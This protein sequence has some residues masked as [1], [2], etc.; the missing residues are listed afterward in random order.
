MRPASLGPVGD[1]PGTIIDLTGGQRF[2][3]QVRFGD[4]LL[5]H[6]P[7]GLLVVLPEVAELAAGGR[8]V[9]DRL[10]QRPGVGTVGARQ[11]HQHPAGTPARKVPCTHG[12][13]RQRRQLLD[14]RQTPCHPT[15]MPPHLSGN[16]VLVHPMGALELA[17]HGR[18]FEHIELPGPV[19]GQKLTQGIGGTARPYLGPQRIQPGPPGSSNP[20]VAV[21]EHK[22]GRRGSHH[23]NGQKLTA[24]YQRIG[25][26]DDLPRPLDAGMGVSQIQMGNFNAAYGDARGH[27]SGLTDF[28]AKVPRVVSLQDGPLVKKSP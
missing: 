18:L 19:T 20:L 26:G 16:S 27:R 9:F 22:S 2:E 1:D 3:E 28:S 13:D 11:R 23:H 25:Q 7:V 5:A 12:L 24:A 6:G 4:H 8:V 10:Q 14:E 17:Q 21:D 15:W